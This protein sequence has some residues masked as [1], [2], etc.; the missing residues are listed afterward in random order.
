MSSATV[1]AS[2]R[3]S[4]YLCDLP[5]MPWA[6]IWDFTQPICRGCVN[7]EGAD[8]IE[9]VIET[10]RQL[11]RAHGFQEGRSLGPGKQ[12]LSGKEIQSNHHG[13]GGDS[14]S[15]PPQPLDRYP[16]SSLDRP[17]RLG[18]EYQ[19]GRQANGIPVPN[20]FP[21]PDDPPELNR[22][23]PNP[24]RNNTV[25]PNLV[26]L[27][28]GNM[29]SIHAV[30]SRPLRPMAMGH[31][32][33]G[34][35]AG[36]PNEHGGVKRLV[37][38]SSSDQQEKDKQHIPDSLTP[39]I[40]NHKARAD[41][42]MNKEKTV[43][44]LM[45]LHAFDSRF[46]KDHA[47]MH[48]RVMGY[49]QQQNAA[50][51]KS[52]RGKHPRNM[53]RKA[54]PEP[55]G[56]REGTASKH[57]GE[58]RQR[59]L[60]GPPSDCDGHKMALGPP[61]SISSIPPT[62]SPHSRTTPPEAGQN[63]Q[64]P[65]A[66]LILAADN[67]GGG[68]NSSPKDGNQVHSTTRR[69]SSSPLSPSSVNQNRRQGRE[70]SGGV[71]TLHAPGGGMMDQG[72]QSIPDSSVPGSTPLCCTLCRERLEDTHFVQCPSVP[73]HKFCFPCSR[74]SIKQQ[75]ATGEVYCPS[76]EKCPLVGSNVPWA[77]MQGEIATILDVKVKKE[78][79]P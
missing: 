38:V 41:E 37:S 35:M 25:P 78:R 68:G 65:M 26:P 10:A 33:S 74:E 3:Q 47:A 79:D 58:D 50:A 75:G 42:W 66:A 45:V 48:Q 22:Q 19:S 5:R 29:S 53:K 7:Y 60:P 57:N 11:K 6:M 39:E 17:L 34:L 72:H 24:R 64:S 67:A 15:R 4:C 36:S 13:S 21:K 52:D 76:G 1:A 30:N 59:W 46:K 43:R 23:S 12:Q 32:G 70:A 40:E 73:S 18:P 9:F 71:G 16:L 27:V 77:F 55:E 20:G 69:N 14:G 61:P 8:R 56:E 51:S 44:D 63:G 54:S 2:R 62:I 28:N 31:P 49:E